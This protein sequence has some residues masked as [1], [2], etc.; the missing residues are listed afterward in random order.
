MNDPVSLVDLC[1]YLNIDN[2]V[3]TIF[4]ID[5]AFFDAFSWNVSEFENF[6]VIELS[7]FRENFQKQ[8]YQYLKVQHHF[9]S[10]IVASILSVFSFLKDL[11]SSFT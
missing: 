4:L 1:N 9:F 6:V 2:A 3:H 8:R 5:K 11:L 10:L 7:A